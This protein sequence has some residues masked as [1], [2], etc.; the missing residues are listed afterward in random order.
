VTQILIQRIADASHAAGAH[1]VLAGVHKH[2]DTE[3]VLRIFR[4]DRLHT[5]DISQDLDNPL[6]R[7]LPDNGHPNALA[8]EQMAEK[9]HS[10]LMEKVLQ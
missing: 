6:L 1:F 2:P 4:L 7:I 10:Y 9:L 8:H 5:V 3:K